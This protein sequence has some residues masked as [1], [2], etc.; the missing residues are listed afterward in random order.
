VRTFD[1]WDEGRPGMAEIDLVGHEGGVS[2]G[3]FAFTLNLT[4]VCT[5]WTEPRAMKNK[6]QKWTVQA[7]DEIKAVLPFELCGVHSDN[8]S[9][10]L[11]AHL[12][13]YCDRCNIVFTRS[14]PYR[15]NDNCFVEQK[16]N[17]VVRRYVG[18]QRYEGEQQVAL[19]NELYGLVRLF[20]NYFQ[21]SAKLIHKSREG[22]KVRKVYDEPQTPC[23]RVLSS[24]HVPEAAKQR[25][26]Q[27]F[28][29]LNPAQLQREIRALQMRLFGL[30]SKQSLTAKVAG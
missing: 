4:D 2:R 23:A 30:A 24:E 7:L 11:N 10:F 17:D 12:V 5:G 28:E 22:S 16:N 20:V 8:G 26:R 19:L 18:Y 21:P 6:A 14:R 29:S 27:E 9:E 1:G 13:R 15:K 3:E 25:L